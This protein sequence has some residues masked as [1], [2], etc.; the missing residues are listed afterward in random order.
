M[1]KDESIFVLKRAYTDIKHP[2]LSLAVTNVLTT[3]TPKIVFVI[4]PELQ[5]LEYI[6][7]LTNFE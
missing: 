2:G 4:D 7:F 3:N 1:C 6:F 5:I